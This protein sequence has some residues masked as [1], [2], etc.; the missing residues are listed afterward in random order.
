MFIDNGIVCQEN[1]VE[2]DAK[3]WHDNSRGYYLSKGKSLHRYV[4]EQFMGPIP[5]DMVIHHID[6]DKNNN[7]IGNLVMMT[8]SNHNRHHTRNMSE[9]TKK[10]IGAASKG[11]KNNLG[12]VLTNETK[13]KISEGNRGKTISEKDRKSH[14]KNKLGKDVILEIIDEIPTEEW[15][16]WEE[17]YI[18]LFKQF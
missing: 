10:K 16:Y 14:H 12:K 18:L 2:Y 6:E 9:Q 8:R 15:R 5:S 13:R 7:T 3:I 11:N 1:E 4:Y 17:F